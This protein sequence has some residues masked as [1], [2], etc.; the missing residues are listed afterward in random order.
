[1]TQESLRYRLRHREVDQAD[2]GLLL[3]PLTW[4]R[5]DRSQDTRSRPKHPQP[6]AT[7][8]TS[9]A[10]VEPSGEFDADDFDEVS[11]NKPR[12]RMEIGPPTN[13]PMTPPHP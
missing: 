12:H 13:E 1:M 10:D 2:G 3:T 11:F 6:P 8:Q 7:N 4:G 9:T 5:A